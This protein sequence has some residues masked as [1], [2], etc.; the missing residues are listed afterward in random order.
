MKP[1]QQMSASSAEQS[2]VRDARKVSF[3]T[4]LTWIGPLTFARFMHSK[5]GLKTL[6]KREWCPVCVCSTARLGTVIARA[7]RVMQARLLQQRA[8]K[9][10]VRRL[11]VLFR[12]LGECHV[13]VAR[14]FQTNQTDQT[15]FSTLFA[16]EYPI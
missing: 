15:C 2:S 6:T 14:D 1:V 11:S 13:I 9:F 3:E 5:G 8:P 4:E 7:V 10:A 12:T 16:V